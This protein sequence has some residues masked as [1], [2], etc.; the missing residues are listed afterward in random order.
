MTHSVVD[1]VEEHVDLGGSQFSE[2]IVERW[3]F[4]RI[5]QRNVVVLEFGSPRLPRS[6]S[7]VHDSRHDQQWI[8]PIFYEVLHHQR[9]RIAFMSRTCSRAVLC[10]SCMKRRSK[11]PRSFT[12]L[13]N[14]ET[15][16]VF[17]GTC[18]DY[19]CLKSPRSV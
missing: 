15:P 12:S 19:I 13:F 11:S 16:S 4:A 6:P 9:E 8:F 14:I 3:Y 17:R 1:H 18:L 2:S 5:S 10:F 7:L